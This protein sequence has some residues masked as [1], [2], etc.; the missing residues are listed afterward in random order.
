MMAA[1]EGKRA[2]RSLDDGYVSVAL[3][4]KDHWSVLAYTET[5]MVECAGFEVGTDARMRACRRHF[6]VLHEGCPA[7]RRAES[8]RKMAMVMESQHGTILA[9][10]SMIE[11]HD[12]WH[13]LQDLAEAGFLLAGTHPASAADIEPGTTLNLSSLGREATNQLRKHKADGGTFGNFKFSPES[14]SA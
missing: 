12:D 4:G 7:P 3:F 11:G 10:G 1:E 13:C 14:T 9:D 5:V 2:Q 8:T 6:R